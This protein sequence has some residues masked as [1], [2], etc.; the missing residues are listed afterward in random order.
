[1]LDLTEPLLATYPRLVELALE[2]QRNP[3]WSSNQVCIAVLLACQQIV[4]EFAP[5]DKMHVGRELLAE[6]Q[7]V[8]RCILSMKQLY[9]GLLNALQE[10]QKNIQNL[11]L[12]VNNVNEIKTRVVSDIQTYIEEKIVLAQ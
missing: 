2:L 1:V 3:S 12:T 11:I 9:V 4:W 10:V 8:V 5:A 7:E 6:W